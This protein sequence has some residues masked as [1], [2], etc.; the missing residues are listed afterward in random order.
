[1]VDSEKYDINQMSFNNNDV[2]VRF[3]FN[4]TSFNIKIEFK[5]VRVTKIL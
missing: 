5:K 4:L 2:L 3:W 1:M